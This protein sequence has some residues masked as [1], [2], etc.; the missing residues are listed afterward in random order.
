MMK[1][2]FSIIVPAFIER[3]VVYF[4]L[5]Y[6]K[7]H[8]GFA[9]RKIKLTQGLFAIVDGEDFDELDR[10][11]WHARDN[12]GNTFYAIRSGER[13]NGKKRFIQ[14]HR[15]I[16]K[17]K[18]ELVIDHINGNGLDN[19]RANLRVVTT[20]QNSYNRRKISRPCSSK[21]KGVSW[22]KREGRWQSL[23]RYKGVKKF[24][25]YFDD[26]IEAAKRYDEAARIYYGEYAVLNVP[27][28]DKIK[29][30]GLEKKC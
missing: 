13:K 23:I 19:R 17:Y 8:Y 12:H 21:Y 16:M 2:S 27:C 6:R 26:E 30:C 4:L 29:S 9:F 10:Y 7:K 1:I 25:G 11:K 20:A 15:V 14:M 24:L 28:A 5:R 22:V 18:G 3:I